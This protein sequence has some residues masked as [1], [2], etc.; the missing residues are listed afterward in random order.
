[1]C[2]WHS[3]YAVRWSEWCGFESYCIFYFFQFFALFKLSV[4]LAFKVEI[5]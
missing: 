2:Q 5:S 3:V 1:M 4:Y